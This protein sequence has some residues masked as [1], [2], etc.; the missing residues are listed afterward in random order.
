[1]TGT[2]DQG[3]GTRAQEKVTLSFSE[4]AREKESVTFSRLVVLCLGND[5]LRD[6]GVG[7]AVA[8]AVEARLTWSLVPGPR[9]QSVVVRKTP[10][11]G[12][13]LLDELTGYDA[14]VVVDAVRTGS[15]PPGTV[16]SMP[17]EALRGESGPSPHA[18]G[19]PTV[20]R[21]GRQSGVPLPDRIH[22][23]AV[24]VDDMESIGET[25]TPAVADAVPVA[26]DAVL[27]ALAAVR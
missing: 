27:A 8:D 6:D 23:V 24:E 25:L 2:G 1:M 12:F 18:A 7:W 4:I 22:V 19:L 14:A 10:L 13:Y 3:S 9:S 26:R 11:S 20:M 16:L 21:L 17:F 5:L 15:H